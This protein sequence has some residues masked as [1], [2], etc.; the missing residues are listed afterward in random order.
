MSST[1]RGRAAFGAA[2]AA[3]VFAAGCGSD[4]NNKS[5][6]SADTGA[7]TATQTAASGGDAAAEVAAYS[8]T[9]G[10]KFPQPTEAFDPGTG[11]VAVI[12]CG[13]AGINCLQGAKDVQIAAKAMGW[14]PSQIFDG[15]FN[16]AKQAGFVQQAVQQKYD[17]IVMVSMDAQSIK[18]AVDAAAAAKIPIACVM[19]VN[20]AFKGKVVDVSSGGIA[21]G[22]AIGAWIA[23][24]AKDGKAK[25]V[26]YD[27]KS[28]PI[29]AERRKNM[30]QELTKLC[31]GCQVENADFPTSD[32]AK[33]GA[34]TFT[35]MLAS[36]P[37]GQLDFVAAP[38]DPAA[39]PF[40][41]AAAQQ[42]RSDFKMTGYDASPDYVKLME[43]G[44][45]GAAA[46]TAAPFPYASWGAM[47]QVARIKAGKQA[48]VSDK[49]PVALV[50]KDNA[51]DVA[52]GFFA[53]ADF[54]YKAMFSKLWGKG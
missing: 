36:H 10:V 40:A 23:A 53:P 3:L 32:L 4:N 7:K 5:A 54:D 11:K 28:F 24:N 30:T 13:N 50:T 19:C 20:P 47:D 29:V 31:P 41:K 46:T 25:I 44:T 42:G 52:G 38:Y 27:D 33:A 22:K 43:K 26:S 15:E 35:G 14:T 8:K 21:E 37:T 34:P 48:W 2:L 16:P 45:G 12:S 18:A 9:A 49:L 39:I 1:F 17:G 51:S 6:T